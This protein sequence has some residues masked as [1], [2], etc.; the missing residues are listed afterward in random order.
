MEAFAVTD[1]VL[2]TGL[3]AKDKIACLTC[4]QCKRR[5]GIA[6]NKP[7][8]HTCGAVIVAQKDGA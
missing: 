7:H 8:R 3:N 6:L 2:E 5:I 1:F 4:P